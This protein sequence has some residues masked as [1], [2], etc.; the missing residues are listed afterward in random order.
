[1]TDITELEMIENKLIRCRQNLSS[2]KKNYLSLEFD[3]ERISSNNNEAFSK[4]AVAEVNN[5]KFV[6]YPIETLSRGH[7]F[8]P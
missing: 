1:M 4:D 7:E 2:L 5:Y 8:L 6:D 3:F